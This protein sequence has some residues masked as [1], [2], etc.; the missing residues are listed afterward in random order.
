M[1][2]SCFNSYFPSQVIWTGLQLNF[3][4]SFFI[5]IQPRPESSYVRRLA[6]FEADSQMHRG[7]V[8]GTGVDFIHISQLARAFSSFCNEKG[9]LNK[10]IGFADVNTI[11]LRW[12]KTNKT[13]PSPQTQHLERSVFIS[14]NKCL[15]P[16]AGVLVRRTTLRESSSVVGVLGRLSLLVAFFFP[17]RLNGS[18]H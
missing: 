11:Y 12:Q 17:L 4:C 2:F 15:M 8:L 10:K 1:H 6:S 9:Q 18:G 5:R 14:S 3:T 16:N 13:Q 7:M